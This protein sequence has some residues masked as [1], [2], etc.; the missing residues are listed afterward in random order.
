MEEDKINDLIEEKKRVYY[1]SDSNDATM[2]ITALESIGAKNGNHLH[3]VC[4]K[5]SN[6]GTIY[7]I[8]GSNNIVAVDK[9]NFLYPFITT[10]Y[11]KLELEYIPRDKEMVL[12]WDD[13]Y[14]YC[15]ALTFYNA[16]DKCTI[17]KLDGYGYDHYAPAT[18]ENIE[19]FKHDCLSRMR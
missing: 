6:K 11:K 18:P 17:G 1:K 8:D 10:Y 4:N 15:R 7:F 5:G 13:G 19:Q 12:A 2:I 3:G 16:K 14:K 9:N